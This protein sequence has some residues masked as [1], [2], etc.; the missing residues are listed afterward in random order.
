MRDIIMYSSEEL[1][2]V[3]LNEEYYYNKLLRAVKRGCFDDIY[4]LVDN[5]F[6]Y[7][8]EQLAD[9]EETFNNEVAEYNQ[10]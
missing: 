1:S 5:D 8:P 6:I 7:D 3:F 9:L 10:E 2:L 4:N